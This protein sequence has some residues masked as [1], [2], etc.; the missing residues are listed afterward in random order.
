MEALEKKVIAEE[1]QDI[2]FNMGELERALNKTN[3]TAPGKG[4]I[5]YIMLRTV[6]TE[7]K[8]KLLMLFNRV[9]H[10][11]KIP[12]NWKE[13]IIIPIRKPGKDANKPSKN[14]PIAFNLPHL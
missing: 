1:E 5:S 14:R 10:G 11:G 2:P 6:I 9:W 4:E 8:K 3:S 12:E 13:A 7:G